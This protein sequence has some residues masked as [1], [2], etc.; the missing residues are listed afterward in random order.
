VRPD[1]KKGRPRGKEKDMTEIALRSRIAVL[2]LAALLSIAGALGTSAF[3]TAHDAQAGTV[4]NPYYTP[5]P[6][7]CVKIATY[8]Y[9]KC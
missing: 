8:P 1:T 7:G 4:V 9:I 2:V 5:L 3:V 6:P